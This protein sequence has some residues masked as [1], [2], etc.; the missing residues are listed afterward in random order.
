M[1]KEMVS[2][3]SAMAGEEKARERKVPGW[4]RN[5]VRVLPPGPRFWIRWRP[6]R[7]RC[8]IGTGMQAIA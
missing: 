3:S 4:R 8:T 5:V 6:R 2:G 1:K 7:R